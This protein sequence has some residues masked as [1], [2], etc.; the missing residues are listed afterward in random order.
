MN[1]I[2]ISLKAS[3]GP[4]YNSNNLRFSMREILITS[5]SL[6]FEYD[7]SIRDESSSLEIKSPKNWLVI[8]ADSS[9]KLN[10]WS[11]DN[12]SLLYFFTDFGT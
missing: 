6:N 4:W 3:V 9:L 11:F 1:C 10:F 2:A 12:S 7:L 5:F 8:S